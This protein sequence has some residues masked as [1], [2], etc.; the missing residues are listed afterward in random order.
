MIRAENA[1]LFTSWTGS[2]TSAKCFTKVKFHLANVCGATAYTVVQLYV[3]FYVY[4]YF[5]RVRLF[6]RV[7][8]FLRARQGSRARTSFSTCTSRLKCMSGPTC[9][10]GL[11]HTCTSLNPIAAAIKRNPA[12]AR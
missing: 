10:S 9:T 5:V 7:R 8:L 4:V 6:R 11:M 2:H 3:Y 12:E 1:S